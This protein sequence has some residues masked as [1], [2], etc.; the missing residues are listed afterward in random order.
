MRVFLSDD[1]A[2][3]IPTLVNIVAFEK[4]EAEQL[5]SSKPAMPKFVILKCNKIS[6]YVCCCQNE[7]SVSNCVPVGRRQKTAAFD[8]SFSRPVLVP[9]S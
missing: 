9:A 7:I 6:F 1:R 3:R 2:L 8:A 4:R 5:P